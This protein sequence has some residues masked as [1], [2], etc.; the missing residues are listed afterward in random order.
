MEHDARVLVGLLRD[1]LASH[2]RP[3]SFLFGAG[4]S[5]A[6]NVAT[7]GFRPLIPAVA[8]LTAECKLD[9]EKVG[10]AQ[11]NA[12][13]KMCDECTAL[14]LD[15]NIE[16]LLGRIRSK[17]EALAPTD[18][19][20]GLKYDEWLGVDEVIRKRIAK[21]AAPP[22]GAMPKLLPHHEFTKWVRNTT[23]RQPIEIFTTNYDVLFETCFDELRVPH[24][25]GFIG[26]QYPF[27]S[28]EAVE[29]DELLPSA[30]WIRFWK[31]HGSVAWS[32]EMVGADQRIT[33]GRANDAGEMILPSHR[34]YDE[35]RKQPYRSL[36]DRLGR[37]LARE[38]SLLF[39]CGFSFGDQHINAIVLDALERRPRTHLVILAFG[40]IDPNMQLAKWAINRA[41]VMVVGPNAGVI[42][43]RFGEWTVTGTPD[44]QLTLATGGLV[45]PDP[46]NAGKV[47]VRAGDFNAFCS[48]LAS[49]GTGAP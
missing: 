24:F 13:A 39:A 11:T 22:R 45:V 48:F 46:A 16:S 20:D 37:V 5:S 14:R 18:S 41:N 7:A 10:T 15:P 38:D 44:P 29:S 30:A 25:D 1:H 6:V 4:T 12:W 17:L 26:S 33:R 3:V 27:F 2:D 36:L 32:L 42:S 23:R 21:L 47:R 49:M 43:G 35:S 19:M 34:K 40:D 9:V 8:G 31:V 28:P